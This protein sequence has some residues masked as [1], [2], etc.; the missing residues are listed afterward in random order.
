MVSPEKRH[1]KKSDCHKYEEVFRSE[2]DVSREDSYEEPKDQRHAMIEGM[3]KEAG[4]QS[5]VPP[6]GL[7]HCADA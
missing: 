5:A 1:T 2:S 3:P 7:A 4:K 6:P